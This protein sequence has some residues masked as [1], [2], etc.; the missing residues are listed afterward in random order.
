MTHPFIFAF[1]LVSVVRSV[2]R[3]WM[4]ALCIVFIVALICH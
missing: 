4:L 2:L 1:V 3:H